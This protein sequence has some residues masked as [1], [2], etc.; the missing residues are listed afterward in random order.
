MDVLA[1]EQVSVQ[2]AW[3]ELLRDDGT[4]HQPVPQR[5]VASGEEHIACVLLEL[6]DRPPFNLLDANHITVELA[7]IAGVFVQRR[8]NFWEQL[9]LLE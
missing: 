8:Q 6:R 3:I 2:L 7:L 4:I 5:L 1:P 9:R